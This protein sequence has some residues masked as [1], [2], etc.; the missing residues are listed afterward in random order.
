MQFGLANVI[1]TQVAVATET[2]LYYT[3]LV[4]C[5]FWLILEVFTLF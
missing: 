4:F 5:Q 2:T 3:T 1:Y